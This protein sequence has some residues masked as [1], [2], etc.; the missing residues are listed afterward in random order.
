[1]TPTLNLCGL[2]LSPY[3]CRSGVIRDSVRRAVAGSRRVPWGISE[4]PFEYLTP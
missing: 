3:D 4:P 2:I 1:M